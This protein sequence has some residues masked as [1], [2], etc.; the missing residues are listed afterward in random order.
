V[1]QCGTLKKENA[2]AD[3]GQERCDYLTEIDSEYNGG[4]SDRPYT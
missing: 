2:G 4:G 3:F 1:L